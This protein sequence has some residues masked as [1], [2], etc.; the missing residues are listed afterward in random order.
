MLARLKAVTRPMDSAT[1]RTSAATPTCTVPGLLAGLTKL[2]KLTKVCAAPALDDETKSQLGI[3]GG[4]DQRLLL[5]RLFEAMGSLK[6][7]YIKLQIAHIP[8]DPA[9]IAFAD[10]IITSEF[11]SVTALQRLCSWSCGIGSLVNERWSL[12]QELEAETRKRDS[13]IVVLKRELEALQRENS[14]LNRQIKSEKLSSSKQKS[15]KGSVV[16][17]ELA[18][19][20]PSTVLELFKVASASVHDFAELIA[21]SMMQASS[22]NC[23]V[24]DAA[25][26]QSWT[27]RRYS[28]EAHLSRT[29]L[30]GAIITGTEEEEEEDGD[31]KWLKM[32]GGRFD[33]IMRFCDPL[34][35]LMQYPI[36]GFSRFCRSRYLAAVPAETEA[37]VFR[38][39]DQ[40]AFV[41]RGGHPRTWFY[42]AFATT[43]EVGV[44]AACGHGAVLRARTR[45]Q[46]VVREERERVR[47]G[48]DGERGGGCTCIRP[49]EGEGDMEEK[50]SGALTVTPGVKVGATVVACRVLLR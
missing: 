32:S 31:T 9:K 47:G 1:P 2:C 14:R 44:G 28:L 23:T 30:V 39:L 37:A 19:A 38:N 45:C 22:D 4:Y 42:R 50:L 5:I 35:A 13:D 41:A 6:S 8:Y 17:K 46:N 40:R 10:E 48:V 16:P 3:C 15:D 7:A 12:V 27:W 11:D 36:S 33:R 26:E 43:A 29:M 34:D 20:T 25:V 24:N 49:Q 21:T 18:T